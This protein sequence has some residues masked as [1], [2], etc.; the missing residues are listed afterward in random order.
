MFR[1]SS[2]KSGKVVVVLAGRYAG[3]KAI[4]VKATDD[5][6]KDRKFGH[7]IGKTFFSLNYTHILI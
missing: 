4:I 1:F 2:Y 6:T 3:K 5:G 7:A